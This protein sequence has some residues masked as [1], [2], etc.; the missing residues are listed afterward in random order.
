MRH[1]HRTELPNH[2][3]NTNYTNLLLVARTLLAPVKNK[4]FFVGVEEGSMRKE[5][6]RVIRIIRVIRQFIV[7]PWRI[8]PQNW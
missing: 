1:G 8:E 5:Q 7:R 6:I 2:T 4:T 3:N